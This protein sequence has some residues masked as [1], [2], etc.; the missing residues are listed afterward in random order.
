MVHFKGGEIETFGKSAK[1]LLLLL[2][3]GKTI[4]AN[5]P[6][7]S[8]ISLCADSPVTIRETIVSFW[9]LIQHRL[10]EDDIDIT[11][12]ATAHRKPAEDG[13]W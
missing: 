11:S 9:L 13:T 1:W 8:Q 2:V 10:E 7:L 12:A 4:M 6:W 3:A 5:D